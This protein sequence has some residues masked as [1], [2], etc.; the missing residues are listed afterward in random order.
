MKHIEEQ[1]QQLE[2]QLQDHNEKIAHQNKLIDEC[3]EESRIIE[4][5]TRHVRGRAKLLTDNMDHLIRTQYGAP[6]NINRF[7]REDM[8]MEF[9]KKNDE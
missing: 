3:V 4:E 1:S 6:R 7:N 8:T 9:V 2:A 5:H